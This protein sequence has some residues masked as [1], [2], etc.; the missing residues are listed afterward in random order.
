MN[1]MEDLRR[2]LNDARVEVEEAQAALEASMDLR[3]TAMLL[4]VSVQHLR[5]KRPEGG[6]ARARQQ[7]A[8]RA[9]Q[10]RQIQEALSQVKN[11]PAMIG[12]FQT[13]GTKPD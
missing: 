13:L 3:V 7:W 9:E 1:Q 8:R 10:A 2:L 6:E 5:E 4:G 12:M 11:N